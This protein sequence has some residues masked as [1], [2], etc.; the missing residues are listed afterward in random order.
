M[1]APPV[2][3]HDPPASRKMEKSDIAASKDERKGDKFSKVGETAAS[4]G[5]EGSGRLSSRRTK[6]PASIRRPKLIGKSVEGSAVQAMAASRA[7]ASAMR[8]NSPFQKSNKAA[9][10][11]DAVAAPVPT[12]QVNSSSSTSDGYSTMDRKQL[13]GQSN[14]DQSIEVPASLKRYA[15]TMSLTSV[16]PFQHTRVIQSIVD[17]HW[18]MNPERPLSLATREFLL[19]RSTHLWSDACA[20]FGFPERMMNN[21]SGYF[22]QWL[23]MSTPDFRLLQLD[24]PTPADSP[25]SPSSTIIVELKIVK[26]RKLCVVLRTSLRYAVGR[27]EPKLRCD[28]WMLMLL[29]RG[30]GDVAPVRA[31]KKRRK[32]VHRI[33]RHATLFDKKI[34]TFAVSF[35]VIMWSR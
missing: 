15:A 22:A 11:K 14:Q 16:S 25:L 1:L 31:K 29:N 7:R 17:R 9:P 24:A 30:T 27:T 2:T 19:T 5:A 6:L 35:T 13:G 4:S 10:S 12:S 28:A 18:R 21:L 34:C 32:P 23:N 3:K 8:G 26:Q 20:A 33:E